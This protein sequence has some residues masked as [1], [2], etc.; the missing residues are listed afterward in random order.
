MRNKQAPKRKTIPDP[1]Y[2]SE[3][4]SKFVVK[5]MRDGKKSKA[6]IIF[7][8]ALDK[9]ENKSDQDGLEVFQQALNN[10]M[11]VVEVRARRVGGSTFQ[12]PTEVRPERRIAMGIRWLITYARRRGEK[13]M[14]ERLC[15]E[16]LAASKG[17]GAA[18]K[19]KE[20]THRMAEANKAF[21]HFRF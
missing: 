2:K 8:N 19:K 21:S 4:V 12:I 10:V 11:P 18:V 15:N 5:M 6:Y 20:D 1:K 16:L 9:I 17:E 13:D 3:L 7:Y 14:A